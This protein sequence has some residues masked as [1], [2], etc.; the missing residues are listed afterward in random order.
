MK[1]F[2]LPIFLFFSLIAMNVTRVSAQWT[3]VSPPTAGVLLFDINFVTDNIGFAVGQN[4]SNQMGY[5]FKTT[6]GGV[7]WT[8]ETFPNHHLRS[9]AFTDDNNGIVGGYDGPPGTEV[10][11][12]TTTDQGVNWTPS[13]DNQFT[14]VNGLQ[15][16][17]G[18]T[19]FS[20]GYASVFAASGGIMKTT[21][22]G[23]NWT[24]QSDS[25]GLLI[26]GMYF[27]DEN[28][29]FIST[30]DFSAVGSIMETTDG[31]STFSTKYT[32]DWMRGVTFASNDVGYAIEG[33]GSRSLVKTTDGG[34]NWTT[35]SI[36]DN[37]SKLVFITEDIGYAVGDGGAIFK[38]ID[39]GNSWVDESPTTTED[40]ENVRVIGKYVYACGRNSTVFKSEH[41]VF[42]GI[43]DVKDRNKIQLTVYPNP[44]G[45]NSVLNIKGMNQTSYAFDVF[46]ST[47][48]QVLEKNITGNQ[49]DIS[50]ANLTKGVYLYQIRTTSNTH[51]GR[52]VIN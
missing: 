13:A 15:F 50:S 17:N 26:E 36:D 22:G 1:R 43:N 48:Q 4:T 33:L 52:L 51:Y 49:I 34:N 11:W 41:G 42:T 25:P 38:T 16:I 28:K 8:Q 3:D 10:K 44:L 21:D 23:S 9:V 30:A 45:N 24:P 40:F 29:G 32:G 39:G 47:G 31:G 20:Y 2:Y 12:L 7:N 46:N 6:D 5:V 27:I 37:A 35:L 18:Q 19:G 14:G